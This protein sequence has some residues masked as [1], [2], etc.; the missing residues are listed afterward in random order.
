[1]SYKCNIC[2]YSTDRKDNFDKHLNTAKH[3]KKVTS[4]DISG[5]EGHSKFTTRPHLFKHICK[6]C[7][8]EFKNGFSLKRHQSSCTEV[9]KENYD[10]KKDK[11]Y[12]LEKV[13]R[14]EDELLYF[15]DLLE[16]NADSLNKSV[17]A[18][19]VQEANKFLSHAMTFDVITED[20]M[21]IFMTPKQLEDDD[22]V[23]NIEIKDKKKHSW[24]LYDCLVN[25]YNKGRDKRNNNV[26]QTKC[27]TM[28]AK[29]FADGI[30]YI[31]GSEEPKE[32]PIWTTDITRYNFII[33][34][35]I[36]NTKKSRWKSDKNGKLIRQ[37]AINPLLEHVKEQLEIEMNN[38]RKYIK[39]HNKNLTAHKMLQ[40]T[41]RIR[42]A[43]YIVRDIDNGSLG[44]EIIKKI[45]PMFKLEKSCFIELKEKQDL[46]NSRRPPKALR[47]KKLKLIEDF[48]K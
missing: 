21:K 17:S 48:I 3:L 20:N 28:L 12:L 9:L 29:H 31:Y 23:V 38:D 43:S 46:S 36:K 10:L 40:F 7:H 18:N 8:Q 15:K 5:L 47:K 45:A 16:V 44:T 35:V 6:F 42:M 34:E 30:Y 39:K 22:K 27:R 33:N 11:E 4:L 14:L 13:E 24:Y 2:N 19:Y 25:E 1:M 26:N 41:D 37:K 32:Q